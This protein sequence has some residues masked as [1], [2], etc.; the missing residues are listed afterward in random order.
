MRFRWI[1]WTAVGLQFLLLLYGT[2]LRVG[3]IILYA[4]Q[5]G[6]VAGIAGLTIGTI[7]YNFSGVA[8]LVFA[9]VAIRDWDEN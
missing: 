7:I 3:D 1:A 2:V 5:G 6:S 8:V 4:V 9:V